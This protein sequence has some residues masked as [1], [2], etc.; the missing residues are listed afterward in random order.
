MRS[1]VMSKGTN[2]WAS[3]MNYW[4]YTQVL[5]GQ[6]DGWAKVRDNRCTKKPIMT[7]ND[8]IILLLFQYTLKM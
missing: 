1:Y 7:Y 6:T 4:W 5:Y 8:I 2:I 3:G